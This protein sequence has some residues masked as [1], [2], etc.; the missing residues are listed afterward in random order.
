MVMMMMAMLQAMIMRNY[1][2]DDADAVDD[3][4][5]DDEPSLDI[6]P[7]CVRIMSI[8][9]SDILYDLAE[10]WQSLFLGHYVRCCCQ[11]S[12]KSC[13]GNSVGIYKNNDKHCLGH[14]MR[15]C[16]NYDKS[17]FFELISDF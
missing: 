11:N 13:F 17:Y 3:V 16:H 12:D 2:D 6:F 4:D 10:L 14:S 1:G 7:N 15:F 9:A 8:I 5:D